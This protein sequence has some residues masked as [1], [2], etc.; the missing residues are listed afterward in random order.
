[1]NNR[2]GKY[3]IGLVMKII[4]N[5]LKILKIK[6]RRVLLKSYNAE[7]ISCNPKYIYNE[8]KK[9]NR[10]ELVWVLKEPEK[11]PDVKAVKY[12][13]LK[14]LYYIV[15]SQYVISNTGFNFWLPKKKKQIYINTWH[16]GGAYKD[17]DNLNNISKAQVKQIKKSAELED[18]FISSCAVFTKEYAKKRVGF[19]GKILEIGTP[20][21][22]FL[23]RNQ[24]DDGLKNSIKNRLGID[25]NCSIVIY[26]PT[27]RDDASAIEEID[28]ES[29]LE[30]LRET[31]PKVSI[32]V[33]GHHLQKNLIDIKNSNIVNVSDYDDMQ[34]LLLISDLLITDYS[35][36]IWDMIHGGK[37]VLLYTPDLDEYLKYRGFHV[38]IKEWNIPYFKTNE[39]L[40]AYISSNYFKNME[41]MI[42]NHKIRFGSF[43]H[44][45]A[46]QKIVEL[47]EEGN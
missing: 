13:S 35:S 18:Y 29:L 25:D 45:N 14:W 36:T 19:K 1:M 38:D 7:T 42:E 39:E 31:Y 30:S 47:L 16:G 46:T 26:A 43:E 23:I 10:Y 34:E 8:L 2:D 5:P 33:R 6:K 9:I 15:T 12:M 17:S 32:L 11:Y 4:T 41:E 24:A 3:Y 44:G 22:D 27:W 37:K 40:I 20:R 28:Y 21:N